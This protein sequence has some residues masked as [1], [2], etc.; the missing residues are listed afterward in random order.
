MNQ[1]LKRLI[2]SRIV[3]ADRTVG[4][5]STYSISRRANG[6]FQIIVFWK[7]KIEKGS[8]R[9]INIELDHN[10]NSAKLAIEVMET[11]LNEDRKMTLEDKL[12]ME[13][14]KIKDKGKR[15]W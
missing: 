4:S 9:S 1:K 3:D 12:K 11:I 14:D 15:K 5:I 10:P 6:T 2:E 7:G 8:E 13:E